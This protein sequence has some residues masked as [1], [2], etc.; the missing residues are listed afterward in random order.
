MKLMDWIV[1]LGFPRRATCMGCGSMLG[2]ER[3]D[4][5]ENCREELAKNWIGVRT[6]KKN[7][8]LDGAAFAHH[9]HGPAG[10][11]VRRLKYTGVQLLADEM[12]RDAAKAAEF[13]RLSRITAVTAVP[14]H[15][16]RLQR[17]GF[18]HSELIA[19]RAAEI[20]GIPYVESLY[21][22]RKAPQQAR[23]SREER[24]RNLDGAFAVLP[25][26]ADIVRGGRIL[27]IDDVWTTGSTAMNCAKAFR[28]AGAEKVYFVAYAYGERKKDG[29]NNQRKESHGAA[30]A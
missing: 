5:C 8:K 2:C 19:R 11:M 21:R 28:A 6:V 3:D 9:Y 15:P 29:K 22:T 27:L 16:R 26:C 25:E 13:L 24:R 1:E 18:N 20:L 30:P 10:G 12:G 7:M 23:L 4:L 14:M 17:R